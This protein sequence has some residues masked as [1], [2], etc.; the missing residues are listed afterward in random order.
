MT[1]KRFPWYDSEW[2]D[3]YVKFKEMLRETAPEKL[4]ELEAMIA[5][6]RTREDFEPIEVKNFLS[7]E[8]LQKAKGFIKNLPQERKEAH[9]MFQFGRAV[10]HNDTLFNDYHASITDC[11]SELVGEEVDPTYNFLALYHN[12]G[13]CEVHM[14]A[15]T[16]KYTVDLLIDQS[17]DW[18]IHI[19][20]WQPWPESMIDIGDEWEERI[21]NDPNVT[22]RSYS[23]EP[24]GGVIFSGSN[25][26]HYRDAIYTPQV[27]NYCHLIFFH[28]MPRNG[29]E[30]IGSGGWKRLMEAGGA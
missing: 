14:D 29:R 6:L 9:E 4:D 15:P 24:G 19:S 18:P 22:F 5:P 26:W 10:V 13:V 8:F 16:A 21:K 7:E 2:L 25:S 28:F 23:M 20:N 1:E 27:R 3:E 12:L 11:V 17:V 30:I